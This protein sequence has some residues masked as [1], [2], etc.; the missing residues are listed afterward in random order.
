[1][2]QQVFD[3]R[4]VGRHTPHTKF[5]QRAVHAG[6]GFF[7]CRGPCRYFGQKRVIKAGDDAAS[8]SR[9]AVQSNAHTCRRSI[10]RDATVVWNEVI[11][12]I[13]CGDAGLKRVTIQAHVFL[14]CFACR[15]FDC[16]AFRNQDLSL[17]NI[18]AGDFFCHGMFDLDARVDFDEEKLARF[19]IHQEFNGACTF[20]IHVLTNLVPKIA[21]F[22]ALFFGQI[23]GRGAFNDFLVAA[24]HRTV[25]FKQ[26][27]HAAMFVAKNLYLDVARTCDHL[28]QIT[29][30][31]AKGRF[32]LA[33][34]FEYFFFDFVLRKDRA[35]TAATTT[36][37]CFQHQRIANFGGL[38]FDCS[39]IVT[40]N[41]GRWNDRNASFHG[42]AS[43]TGF[44]TKSAHRFG[45]WT[46]KGDARFF[47]GVYEFRVFRKQTIAG[48]NSVS[49]AFTG[50]TDDFIN[51]KIGRNRSHA[52]ANAICF[53]GFKSMQPQFVFL[54]ID[55]DGLFAHFVGSAHHAD[56]NLAS[57][58]N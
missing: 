58:S 46:D 26:V 4:D 8:I 7:R 57:V 43:G 47:T 15:F 28:F 37:R 27:I 55:R 10:G 44:V 49:T 21:N 39:D 18:D 48:V 38:F 24:L 56:G 40:Q 51:G 42:D 29:F 33:T 3:E 50:D 1:M 34:T 41:F 19:H 13:F 54:G 6:N 2:F 5:A 11:Q 53:V 17:H 9:A 52:F 12:W 25:A 45:L 20:V 36:P 16:F 14:G 22:G 23:R 30:A 35:H 31:I 32:C